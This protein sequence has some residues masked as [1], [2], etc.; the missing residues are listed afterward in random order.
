MTQGARPAEL[1]DFWRAAGCDRWFKADPGFDAACRAYRPLHEAAARG[2]LAA[3]EESPEGAL[4]L[5]LL[6]D[7]FP[8]N[9]FRGT[10]RAWATD[11]QALAAAERA[12]ARGHDRAIEP[13][14]R[15][16]LYMPLTHAEDLELQERSVALFTALGLPVHLAAAVEHRD[17]IRRFGR[18]P[19]RNAVLGRAESAAERE[20]LAREDAFRG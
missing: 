20:Y 15:I 16:F 12:L 8:R 13:A 17:L 10:T 18:F 7:Q 4:A 6:L 5:V 3:W 19:H 9:L 14:L 1:V 2:A 11:A